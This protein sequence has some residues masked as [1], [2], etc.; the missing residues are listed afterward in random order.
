MSDLK[1]VPERWA[2][3]WSQD[4]SAAFAELFSPKAV[5]TDHAF[6]II[7]GGP[8]TLAQHHNIWRSAHPDFEL[9]IDDSRP[10][11]WQEDTITTPGA[12]TKDVW[13]TNF[14]TRNRGTF[15]GDLPRGRKATGKA[16]V[17]VGIVDAVV[18]K[19]TGLIVQLDEW[20]TNNGF[21]EKGPGGLAEYHDLRDD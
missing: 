12:D 6:Q 11:L 14:R 19:R 7:R 20:Y 9:T 16:F 8:K 21:D 18:E 17:F 1:S 5:Y 2:A 15:K 4:N 3:A 13:R 10:I